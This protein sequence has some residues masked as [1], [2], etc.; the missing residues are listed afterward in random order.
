MRFEYLS[1]RKSGALAN[2]VKGRLLKSRPAC[3]PVPGYLSLLTNLAE[4]F[5]QTYFLNSFG[6]S[7][8]QSLSRLLCRD[9]FVF[10]FG[11]IAQPSNVLHCVTREFLVSYLDGKYQLELTVRD[12]ANIRPLRKLAETNSS[13]QCLVVN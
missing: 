1:V 4:R 3:E 13:G 5:Q 11:D 12:A 10:C 7:R 8:C 6:S 9:K 2:S